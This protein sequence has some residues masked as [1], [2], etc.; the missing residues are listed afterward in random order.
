MDSIKILLV[1]D[2]EEDFILTRDLLSSDHNGSSFEISWCNNYT[3]AINAMLKGYYDLYLLDYRLGK[4]SGLDLLHEAVKSNCTQ[5]IVILTG[6]GDSKIDEE[7]LNMGASDYLT[8]DNL[9]AES[10]IR[11]IR[12]AIR[13]HRTLAQLK[14]SEN[15]FRIIF[16][17]S[18]DPMLISDS[19]G[20]IYEANDAAVKFVET[21]IQ[22]L[23]RKNVIEF[24]RSRA[25]RDRF[26][27]VMGKSGFV[28]DMEIEMVTPSGK[29]KYA[30]ISSFIQISQ[31]GNQELFYSVLHDITEKTSKHEAPADKR[32]ELIER[33]TYTMSNEIYNPLS[34]INF[35]IEELKNI[36]K[37]PSELELIDIIAKNCDRIKRIASSFENELKD[38]L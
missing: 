21:P 20:V 35:A 37:T 27:D 2:D 25:T 6:K 34:N 33:I 9:S 14:S 26:L 16:E 31:H 3:E 28:K 1:D 12:Y 11:T 22:D 23:L 18:K 10:L 13:H 7:A 4:Y 17:R 30:S 15:K 32:Y 24:Y 38:A 29:V 8:K 36:R 5:P 19:D